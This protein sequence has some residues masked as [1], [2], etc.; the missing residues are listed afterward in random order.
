VPY[1]LFEQP[2]LFLLMG[3]SGKHSSL[4]TAFSTCNA[5]LGS[6][7]VTLPWA[8]QKAGWMFSLFLSL[9]AVI[10]SS[11]TCTIIVRFTR[12]DD[13][14]FDCLFKYYGKKGWLL[15]IASATCVIAGA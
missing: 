3:T 14:F 2:N 6:T 10:I 4:V 13:D 15:G 8:F 7:L 5:M 1:H 9:S 11:Y 12:E